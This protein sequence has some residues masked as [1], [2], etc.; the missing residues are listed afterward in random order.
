MIMFNKKASTFFPYITSVAMIIL[1]LSFFIFVLSSHEDSYFDKDFF[2]L[3][4]VDKSNSISFYEEMFLNSFV[5]N[6]A[7]KSTDDFIYEQLATTEHSLDEY[8]REDLIGCFYSN[9]KIWILY[10]KKLVDK[11]KTDD[12]DGVSCLID[13]EEFNNDFAIYLEKKLEEEI[14]GFFSASEGLDLKS[15]DISSASHSEFLISIS[16][17]QLYSFDVGSVSRDNL[18]EFNFVL[19]SYSDLFDTI[20]YVLPELSDSMKSEIPVCRRRDDIS[21]NMINKVEYCIDLVF[22][23]LIQKKNSKILSEFDVSVKELSDI[24]LEGYDVFRISFDSKEGD[25]DLGFSVVLDE[26][27]YDVVEYSLSNFKRLDN[28]IRIDIRKF[29]KE[30]VNNLIVLYSYKDFFNS[31]TY[32]EKNYNNLKNLIVNNKI[33]DALQLT[34]INIDKVGYYHS[35]KDSNLDLT[36]LLIG[37]VKKFNLPNLV[38]HKIVYQIYDFDEE[39]YV[40]FEEG[41][42]VYFAVFAVNPPNFN[43][44]TSEGLLKE[45]YKSITP[46]KVFGP[47]PLGNNEVT[48]T[49]DLPNMESSFVIDIDDI[50][51]EEI[52]SYGL[53]VYKVGSDVELK[54]ECNADLC[55]KGLSKTYTK[56]LVTSDVSNMNNP[57]YEKVIFLGPVFVLENSMNYNIVLVREDEKG[58]GTVREIFKEYDTSRNSV[59]DI[60]Y[61]ELNRGD[62]V[63]IRPYKRVVRI[64]D[65]KPPDINSVVFESYNLNRVGDDFFIQWYSKKPGD[66]NSLYTQTLVSKTGLDSPNLIISEVGI[67]GK[68]E[69]QQYSSDITSIKVRKVS[70]VDS[71]RNSHYDNFN[72]DSAP[73]L[74]P[75]ITWSG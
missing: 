14:E 45:T 60:N 35:K 59:D 1:V 3:K 37:N 34:P 32:G 50:S 20:N 33:P 30:D 42:K 27:P 39:K 74:N 66:V 17:K 2:I 29:P 73:D 69:N 26:V 43:Y 54:K 10:N 19:G 67:D 65:K 6:Y 38:K 68:I 36:V 64:E 24:P 57:N 51:D 7:S 25:L 9:T 55:Y 63:P 5:L 44:F 11:T 15:I 52:Y 46:K 58:H 12:S 8:D 61:Y 75:I 56:V 4:S 47:R 23:E 13:V 53:Y 18:Y 41:R 31:D 28:A 72:I 70:P 16:S 49:K 22:N 40:L 62:S 71:S 21:D 48:I